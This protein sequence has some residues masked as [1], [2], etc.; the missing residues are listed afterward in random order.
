MPPA[1]D[2]CRVSTALDVERL[3]PVPDY[4]TAA[5]ATFT[6]SAVNGTRRIRTPV[7]SKRRSPTR[8]QRA[9]SSLLPAPKRLLGP[10]DQHHLDRR[11][12]GEAQDRIARPV[13]ARHPRLVEVTS[14]C[15]VRLSVCTIPPS[16]WLRSASGLT[17]S[18]QSCAQTTRLTRIT[19][20]D[21]DRLLTS[22]E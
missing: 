2:G 21:D 1:S 11:R 10:L 20:V 19:P 6:R 8:P 5:N 3:Q 12:L 22:R 4:P 9:R 13:D 16:I 7:A 14:S 18:P 17:T 15:S